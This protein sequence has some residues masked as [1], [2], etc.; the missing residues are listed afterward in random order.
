MLNRGAVGYGT[1][2]QRLGRVAIAYRNGLA[3]ISG[4]GGMVVAYEAA[5]RA[6]IGQNTCVVAD[7]VLPKRP[8]LDTPGR[9][10][11][12]LRIT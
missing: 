5:V 11:S 8:T 1:S 10:I 9:K 6:G 7:S 4:I 2:L 3:E 12:R